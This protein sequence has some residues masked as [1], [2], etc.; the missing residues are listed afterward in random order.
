MPFSAQIR[1]MALSD[2]PAVALEL[3]IDPY[4]ALRAAGIDADLIQHPDMTISADRIAWL[5]DGVAERSGFA[6]LGIR[7]AMRRR[8]ATLGVIG[9]VLIQ[10][11][12]ARAALAMT[13]KYLHLM[14][15]ALSVHLEDDGDITTLILGI[16][17]GSAAP[18][19][20]AREL[21]LAAYIHLIRLL[22][23]PNWAPDCVHFSHPAPVGPTIHRSFFKCPVMFG[24][25]FDG[26]ECSSADLDR[27][28]ANADTAL[29]G[30]VAAL[31][32][33][34]PSRKTDPTVSMVTSLI[35]ALLP[36]GRASIE[37]VAKAMGRN[38]RTLQRD[39]G[40]EQTGFSDLLATSRETLAI[41][42]L[43]DEAL[44]VEAISFRLGYSHPAAFIRFFRNRYGFS[45]G[46]WRRLNLKGGEML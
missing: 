32:D 46:E 5:L 1:L 43:R 6:D 9:L 24:A 36:M 31:L 7:M 14:N 40:K 2:F 16:A 21:A 42:M 17:I 39:L 23:G 38:V 27:L 26:L 37:H 25:S 29:A 20:Q 45:P 19:R 30:Y 10:Q 8:L 3:G 18:G 35:H 15:D 34:L 22:L 44:H 11:E 12:S 4:A 28:N 41:E 13:Q 33:T